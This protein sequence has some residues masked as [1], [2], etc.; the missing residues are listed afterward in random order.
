MENAAA[1]TW[2]IYFSSGMGTGLLM[3]ACTGVGGSWGV[4]EGANSHCG[5]IHAIY[6]PPP[7][8]YFGSVHKRAANTLVTYSHIGPLVVTWV[9]LLLKLLEKSLFYRWTTVDPSLRKQF[10][11][12]RIS[13]FNT[14]G[15]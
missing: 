9:Y 4:R 6:N 12:F 2:C 5:C 15:Q 13:G 10:Y 14:K 1:M 8:V 3:C 11:D 7:S